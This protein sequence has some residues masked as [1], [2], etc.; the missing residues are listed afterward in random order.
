MDTRKTLGLAQ[1]INIH[2]HKRQTCRRLAEGEIFEGG[3]FPTWPILIVCAEK[4][5]GKMN[6]IPMGSLITQPPIENFSG[7]VRTCKSSRAT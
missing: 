5:P 4:S 6:S 3:D 1:N 2:F 7:R